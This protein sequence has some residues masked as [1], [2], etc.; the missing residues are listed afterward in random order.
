MSL[1]A[2]H[3]LRNKTNTLMILRLAMSTDIKTRFQGRRPYA[4]MLPGQSLQVKPGYMHL[5]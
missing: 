4:L 3:L 5:E 2:G 1:L